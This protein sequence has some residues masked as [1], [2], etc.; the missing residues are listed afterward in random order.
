[1]SRLCLKALSTATICAVAALLALATV[2]WAEVSVS[3]NLFVT[4]SGNISPQALPRHGRAPIAVSVSGKVRTLAGEHAP[5]LREMVIKLNREGRLETRGLPV[6]RRRQI[7]A[8]SSASALRVCDDALVGTGAYIARTEFPEQK[9]FSSHGRILAFNTRKGGRP[10]ILAHVYS[11][12]PV[13]TTR[14][15]VFSLSHSGG[16]YGTV[17]DAEVPES[18]NRFGYLKRISLKLQRTYTYGGRRRSYLSAGCPAP[19]GL[20]EASFNFA[21]ASMTFVDGRTLW[22]NLTRTCDV[23]EGPGG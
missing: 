16:Q 1:M 19:L 3:G 10:A 2:A 22:S 9:Q 12:N 23:R 8:V 6:C 7:Q 15:F 13:P 4:F 11:D 5:A 17:L 18:L 20:H 21:Y 14:T